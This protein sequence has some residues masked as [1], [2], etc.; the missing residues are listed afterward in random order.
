MLRA[1]VVSMIMFLASGRLQGQQRSPDRLPLAEQFRMHYFIH[2]SIVAAL[3]GYVGFA[4]DNPCNIVVYLM[5]PRTWGDSA[6][7][8]FRHALPADTSELSQVYCG[9]RPEVRA[10]ASRY[11]YAE[12]SAFAN[13]ITTMLREPSLRVRGS[14]RVTPE[15]L[16]VGAHNQ[17]ALKRARSRL[18]REKKLPQAMLAYRVWNPEEVDGPVTPP[19]AAYL[20]VLDTIAAAPSERDR[21]FVIDPRS[22]PGT[23]REDD[24]RKRG[25]RPRRSSATCDTATVVSFKPPRQFVDGRYAFSVSWRSNDYYYEVDCPSGVCRVRNAAQLPGD[26]LAVG[27]ASAEFPNI[28]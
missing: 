22:L 21:P 16:I 14:V 20:A 2:D 12:L 10:R 1:F 23:V 13:R 9:G 11:T 18:A 7:A 8:L 19:R 28:R 27:C 3:P 6:R 26:K 5:N 17:A 15:T 24:L 25:L 4:S